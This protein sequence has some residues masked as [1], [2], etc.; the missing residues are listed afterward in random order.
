MQGSDMLCIAGGLCLCKTLQSFLSGANSP[1]SLQEDFI[2]SIQ[3][4]FGLGA[5]REA[6]N[7][8]ALTSRKSKAHAT[9]ATCKTKPG[10]TV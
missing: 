10:E 3:S 6:S 4:G 9:T 8:T 2:A 5:S 1:N 7:N